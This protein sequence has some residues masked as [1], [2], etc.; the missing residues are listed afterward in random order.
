MLHST[1]LYLLN[2]IFLQ[3]FV[4]PQKA[5]SLNIRWSLTVWESLKQHSARSFQDPFERTYVA[6]VIYSKDDVIT[7]DS[8]LREAFLLWGVM[9]Q[10]STCF[11]KRHQ[12]VLGCVGNRGYCQKV[13]FFKSS[14]TAFD[15][16]KRLNTT[17]RMSMWHTSNI[18]K[19]NKQAN[20]C[21]HLKAP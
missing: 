10:L 1:Q 4:N 11:Y 9:F 3:Y 16:S 15:L 17:L 14:M 6:M 20:T 21:M 8:K 19:H 2:A 7:T 18:A 5:G 12:G 13:K